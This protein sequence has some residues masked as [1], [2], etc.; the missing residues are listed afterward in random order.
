MMQYVDKKDENNGDENKE[1]D[2]KEV[3]NN[4]YVQRSFKFLNTKIGSTWKAQLIENSHRYLVN[5]TET[6]IVSNPNSTTN[7]KITNW[8]WTQQSI[9][10]I[11]G[12][13]FKAGSKVIIQPMSINIS[14]NSEEDSTG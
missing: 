8:K 10:S 9:D 12:K 3:T 1:K 14:S 11:K 5:P 13:T 6:L 4:A 7:L 2:K